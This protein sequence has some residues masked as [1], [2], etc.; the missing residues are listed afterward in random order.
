MKMFRYLTAHHL[1]YWTAA[2]IPILLPHPQI[3]TGTLVNAL[4]LAAAERFRL[5]KAWPVLVLPSISATLMGFLF[6]TAVLLPLIPAIWLG[7]FILFAAA[8]RGQTIIGILAKAA[9]L[10]VYTY[11]LIHL[12]LLPEKLLF[13]MSVVQLLTAFAGFVLLRGVS[14]LWTN[15]RR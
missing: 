11:G 4:I 8:R 14:W 13:P 9:W 1:W 5:S 10:G 15:M 12:G 6:K 7:N 3:L 2:L